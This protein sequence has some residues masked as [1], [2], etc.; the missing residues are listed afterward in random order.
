MGQVPMLELADGNKLV[1]STAIL[2]YIAN[3]Y[4]LRPKE[5]WLVGRGESIQQRFL[6]DWQYKHFNY[7]VWYCP[8]SSQEEEIQ[9][10]LK[11]HVPDFL[12]EM[13]YYLDQRP[14][15][16]FICGDKVTIYDMVI[17]GYIMNVMKNPKAPFA[18]RW[19]DTM[20]QHCPERVKTYLQNFGEEFKSYLQGRP[21]STY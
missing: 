6:K 12:K 13:K 9:K 1:Q 4:G 5:N 19:A 18:D 15:F 21:E 7:P 11:L 2:N 3:A 8:E 16:K 20:E 17:A 14:E 10:L